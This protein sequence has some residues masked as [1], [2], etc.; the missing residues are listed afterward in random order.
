M[1]SKWRTA[2]VGAALLTFVTLT[3]GAAPTGKQSKGNA[4]PVVGVYYYPWYRKPPQGRIGQWRQVMR[5]HLASPQA[6]KLGLYDSNDPNVIGEHIAQSLHGGI[7]FWAVSWWGPG[8]HTD[9]AF[10]QAVLSHRDAGKLK[11]AV[12]YESTDRLGPLKAPHYR[13]WI[14]DLAYLEKT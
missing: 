11:Y 10:R 5:Q 3:V 9:E 2:V 7:A 4:K 12:L 13:H 6:P 1:V 8:H 14:D